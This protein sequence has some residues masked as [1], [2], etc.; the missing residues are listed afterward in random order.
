MCKRGELSPRQNAFHLGMAEPWNSHAERVD[1]R[2]LV[3]KYLD[4]F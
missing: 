1:P 4:I 3:R 2:S